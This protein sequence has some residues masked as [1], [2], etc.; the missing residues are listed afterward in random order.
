MIFRKDR[1]KGLPLFAS[2]LHVSNPELLPRDG[3]AAVP[4]TCCC[5]T[6]RRRRCS[7]TRSSTAPPAAVVPVATSPR[8]KMFRSPT[9]RAG[10]DRLPVQRAGLPVAGETVGPRGERHRTMRTQLHQIVADMATRA[11][12]R[13]GA[14]VQGHDRYLRRA[15]ARGRRAFA[16]G[17][18]AGSAS[19]AASASR[20]T[21]TSAS[22]RSSSIFGTS[23]AGGVFVPVNPLLKAKQ[24]AYILQRLQ[25]PRARD[26]RR[27]ARAAARRARRHASVEHVI[28]LGD[29]PPRRA[30]ARQVTPGTT[31]RRRRPA[32]PTPDVIDIDMA[33]ILYTSGSTGKPKGVVLC[34][35]T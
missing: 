7:S 27:A 23:A 15:L 20:S 17:P 26:H 24:V 30:R 13:P 29:E 31:F 21:S 2:I 28:V 11:R 32:S 10:S 12:R 25:R 5:A 33:A 35:A 6:E 18:A 3:A 9:P 14:D 4:A 8:R 34:T 1:R 16:A 19:I 22:R